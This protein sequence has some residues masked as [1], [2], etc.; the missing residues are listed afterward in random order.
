MMNREEMGGRTIYKSY[1]IDDGWNLPVEVV[2]AI[3]LRVQM[4]W[5]DAYRRVCRE[6]KLHRGGWLTED[7]VRKFQAKSWIYRELYD[8]QY[9]AEVREI[10]QELQEEY[11][12]TELEAINILNG[13]N[14]EDYLNKYDRIQ[15]KI[16]LMVDEQ[17]ICDE[18]VGEY[19]AMAM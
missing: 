9:I 19:M 15:H 12:V 11:G 16:P 8:H 18:I 14:V 2:E 1:V 13:H 17:A 4:A 6:H 7:V 3:D 10:G 5:K